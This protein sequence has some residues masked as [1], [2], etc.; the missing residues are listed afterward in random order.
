MTDKWSITCWQRFLFRVYAVIARASSTTDRTV[1]YTVAYQQQELQAIF[2]SVVMIHHYL[3]SKPVSSN[4]TRI[5]VAR[6]LCPVVANSKAASRQ[7]MGNSLNPIIAVASAYEMAISKKRRTKRSPLSRIRPR[8][9][10]SQSKPNNTRVSQSAIC[11]QK[12]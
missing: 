1:R 12:V 9:R 4:R 8:N 7:R 10:Q 5:T 11:I 3:I 6:R 2:V